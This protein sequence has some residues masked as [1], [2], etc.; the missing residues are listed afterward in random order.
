MTDVIICANFSSITNFATF[1]DVLGL[2][3]FPGILYNLLFNYLT[4]RYGFLP[5]IIYKG[6]TVWV[7]YLIP[8]GSGISDSLVAFINILL[9]IGIYLFIDSLYERKRRY[10]LGNTS[11][12][13][14]FVSRGLT[15]IVI[16]IM[17]GTIMLV[18]N[19]FKYGS[20]VIAT[21]SMT[22]EINMG[23]VVIYE[24]YDDQIIL[25]GQVIAFEKSKSVVIHRVVDIQIIN[26]NTRYYTK[27]DANE[28]MDA[29]F[30]LGDDIIGFVNYKLP[31]LGFPTLW[32][33]SLFK[34]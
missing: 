10:A 30:I 33:R 34:R 20:Y 14:R 21:E 27:G 5:I 25:E 9:P 22:G 16:I 32:M 31:F 23:D 24:S 6:F 4:V 12:V 15:V 29:G 2:T 26:G 28:D 3:L 13:G 1:M 19:Q 18:S 11:R 7:Y 8:Y 17:L